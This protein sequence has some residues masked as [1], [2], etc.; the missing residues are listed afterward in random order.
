MAQSVNP[1]I[2]SSVLDLSDDCRSGKLN[3][4][5]SSYGVLSSSKTILREKKI[6]K[7]VKKKFMIN[8]TTQL[9]GWFI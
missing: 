5:G 3:E 8:T 9:L 2:F 1:I 4:C 6:E 7:N